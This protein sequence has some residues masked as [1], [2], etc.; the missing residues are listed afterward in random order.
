MVGEI[1]L[2]MDDFLRVLHSISAEISDN[3]SSEEQ[4]LFMLE[5]MQDSLGHRSILGRQG[6]NLIGDLRTRYSGIYLNA[7]K[8]SSEDKIS[9]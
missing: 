4:V 3:L 5:R 9:F 6:T 1:S 7:L 2:D 8:K